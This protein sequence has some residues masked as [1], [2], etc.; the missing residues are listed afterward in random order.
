MFKFLLRLTFVMVVANFSCR[1]GSGIGEKIHTPKEFLNHTTA[2]MASYTKDSI[3]ISGQLKEDLLEHKF[4][5]K[6]KEYCDSTAIYIDTILYSPDFERLA[7][8]IITETPMNR[9]DSIFQL[10]QYSH[11]FDAYCYIGRRRTTSKRTIELKWVKR[12]YPINWYNK[13]EISE[14]IREEY[15]TEFGTIQ[16]DNGKP[17][18]RYNFDDKRFW[19]SSI[20]EE[21]FGNLNQ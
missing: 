15:F 6:N 17:K 18:Y 7:V 9:R 5:F 21:Y 8:F 16:D 14:V 19:N 10:K 4:S 12:F 1:Y 11:W 20:W 3:I 13:R 2:S